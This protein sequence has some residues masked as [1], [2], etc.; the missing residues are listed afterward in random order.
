MRAY[1]H[2]QSSKIS[3]IVLW[4]LAGVF[5][6]TFMY[7][8]CHPFHIIVFSGL[9]FLI[10]AFSKMTVLLDN[11]YLTIR[12]GF[13][14]FTKKIFIHDI[15]S[16][17]KVRNKWYY[18]WGIRFVWIPKKTCIYSVYWL[19]AVEITLRNWKQIRIGTDEVDNLEEAIQKRI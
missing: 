5:L 2:S 17:K 10:Y 18:W 6:C 13:G 8:W 4:L 14:F 12:F 16:V 15:V 9:V 11:K 7:S 19:D 1:Q 3:T